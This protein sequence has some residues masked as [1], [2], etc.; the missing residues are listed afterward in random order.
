MYMR[1]KLVWMGVPLVAVAMIASACSSSKSGSSSDSSTAATSVA[2]SGASGGSTGKLSESLTLGLM[3]QIKGESSVAINDFQDASKV[4]LDTIQKQ[5]GVGGQPL[6]TFRVAT[7]PTDAAQL[8]IQFQQGV[9]MKPDAMVGLVGPALEPIL[10]SI[11]TAKIPVMFIGTEPFAAYGNSSGSQYLYE[12][13][14][15]GEDSGMVAAEYAVNELHAKKIAFAHSNDSYGTAISAAAQKEATSL[16]ATVT[17][18]QSYAST[19]TDLTNVV[20]AVKGADAII[21]FGFQGTTTILAKQLDQNGVTIPLIGGQDTGSDVL[22]GAFPAAEAA[23]TKVV[24]NCNAH[25][26]S[27]PAA[28]AFANAY[29]AIH[30]SYPSQGATVT[31]DSILMLGKAAEAAGSTDPSK[32]EAALQTLTYQGVCGTYKS[33][34]QHI[35]LHNFEVLSFANGVSNPTTEK[36]YTVPPGDKLP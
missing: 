21:N 30:G 10:P 23:R 13:L 5:G 35:L 36:T 33:D 9:S 16:G 26:D 29:N 2:S 22:N 31:Y 11:T 14:S 24:A 7:S 25:T 1:A 32:I 20:L 15:T 12:A 19:A 28:Q 4:A 8:A 6:K 3:W 18:N 34:G 27:S 17:T